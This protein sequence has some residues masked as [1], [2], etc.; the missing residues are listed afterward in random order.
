MAPIMLVGVADVISA[1]G[2]R[3]PRFPDTWIE[4]GFNFASKG[5]KQV[6]VVVMGTPEVCVC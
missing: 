3:C 5:S 2:V 6:G 4:I 1:C